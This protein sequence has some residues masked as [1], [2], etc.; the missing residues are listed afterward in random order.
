MTTNRSRTI[1]NDIEWIRG[2]V[3][4]AEMLEQRDGGQIWDDEAR[5]ALENARRRGWG[6]NQQGY[7]RLGDREL[8]PPIILSKRIDE[9]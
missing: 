6:K 9:L 5:L 8:C 2:I 4:A 7:L 1:E 3:R